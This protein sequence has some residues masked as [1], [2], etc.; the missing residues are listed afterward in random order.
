MGL[1]FILGAIIVW[2]VI[3]LLHLSTLPVLTKSLHTFFIT[4]PLMPIAFLISKLI[5]VDFQNKTN[6]LTEFGI[7]FSMNQ[8]LYLIVAMWIFSTISDKMLMVI[9]IIFGAHRLPYAWLYRLKTYL[10]FADFIPIFHSLLT[11]VLSQL[12]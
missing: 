7:L 8:M 4:A 6:P 11:S 12:S 1:H 2:C 5:R 3:T 9:A 10:V